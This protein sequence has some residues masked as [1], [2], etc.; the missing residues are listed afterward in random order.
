[1]NCTCLITGLTFLVDQRDD[2]WSTVNHQ[3]NKIADRRQTENYC[4]RPA[5]GI[6]FF[7]CNG[8]G[9]Q[10]R[11]PKVKKH[12]A[13]RRQGWL[14]DP[15]EPSARIIAPSASASAA[16]Q[17][18]SGRQTFPWPASTDK[19]GSIRQS[20][21]GTDDR[22]QTVTELADDRIFH[23]RSVTAFGGIFSS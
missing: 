6:R 12:D 2:S 18:P 17:S 20:K 9:R 11:A 14:S 4:H 3:C 16:R 19:G 15:A 7:S 13:K 23:P 5:P 1:M 22:F 10:T 21:Q 8:D